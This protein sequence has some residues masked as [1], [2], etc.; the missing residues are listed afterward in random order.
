MMQISRM[1]RQRSVG[2]SNGS[3]RS[4]PRTRRTASPRI[5]NRG[6][7]RKRPETSDRADWSDAG[8]V[9]AAT[10][11]DS[12]GRSRPHVSRFRPFPFPLSILDV[13]TRRRR[14]LSM[15]HRT[16]KHAP[17]AIHGSH[18]GI[19]LAASRHHSTRT[20]NAGI[21]TPIRAATRS[22]RRSR[23]IMPRAPAVSLPV[24]RMA[25][26]FA[27]RQT[28]ATDSRVIADV[29][30]RGARWSGKSAG[31]HCGGSGW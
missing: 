1:R 25:A 3:R 11:L 10:S 28:A 27:P 4:P 5:Q 14:M 2:D 31:T 26:S 12:K 18:A 23:V 17:S 16:L 29:I 8:R 13:V 9:G 22:P 6:C 19:Q 15:L 30:S 7:G 24:R 21:L 20:P